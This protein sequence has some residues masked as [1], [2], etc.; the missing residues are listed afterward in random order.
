M[1]HTWLKAG[2]NDKEHYKVDDKSIIKRYDLGLIFR[3]FEEFRLFLI[4][5]M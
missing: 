1:F 5:F 4:H 3:Y 2:Q